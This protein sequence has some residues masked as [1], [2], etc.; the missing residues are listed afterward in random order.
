MSGTGAD[1]PIWG[2]EG[3]AKR[4]G[5]RSMFSAIAPSYDRVNALVS[6]SEHQRWRI[7]AVHALQL[8]PGDSALDLCCGT[9]DFVKALRQAV[10]PTGTVVGLDFA[11]PMLEIARK[12]EGAKGFYLS[13]DAL[14]IPCAS[15]QFD[16]VTVGWGVRN[17]GDIDRFHREV[18]RVLKPGGR[19][20]SIDMALPRNR[21]VRHVSRAFLSF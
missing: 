21:M 17:V 20:V 2:L 16:S 13:A 15:N 10:G 7:G 1:A 12:K 9:G 18:V 8:N 6:L 11:T 14:S 5:L 4:E 19:F 3:T